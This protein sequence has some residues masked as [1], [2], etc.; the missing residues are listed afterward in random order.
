ML[1]I[2]GLWTRVA[3]VLVAIDVIVAVVLVKP[4]L[5]FALAKTGGWAV[6][7]EGMFLFAALA[8]AFLGAGRLSIGGNSRWN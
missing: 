7:L 4:G 8:V 5:V 6:E 1:L 2:L 3:A